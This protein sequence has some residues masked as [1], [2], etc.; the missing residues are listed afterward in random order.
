MSEIY[1]QYALLDAQEKEIKAKKESLREKIL[2]EMIANKE[3]KIST[4]VGSFSVTKGRPSYKYPKWI[5]DLD[6]DLKAHKAKS[7]ETGEAEAMI[8]PGLLFTPIK[9]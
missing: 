5:E 2:K 1:E 4:T 7:V 3:K 9:I 6:E 8:T